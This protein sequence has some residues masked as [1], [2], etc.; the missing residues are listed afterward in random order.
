[1][2]P[3]LDEKWD[4]KS[5]FVHFNPLSFKNEILKVNVIHHR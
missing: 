4:P 3:E 5:G 2:G 1:M